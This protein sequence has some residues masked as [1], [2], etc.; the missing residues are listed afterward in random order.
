LIFRLVQYAAILLLG[1]TQSVVAASASLTAPIA[2]EDRIV[3]ALSQYSGASRFVEL[4]VLTSDDIAAIAMG[5]VV[6]RV[7]ARSGDVGA[8]EVDAAQTF[9]FQIIAAP[10]LHAWIALLGGPGTGTEGRFTRAMLER[11][12]EGAYVRYQHIDLPWPFQNRHWAILCSK[13]LALARQSDGLIWEHHWS[14]QP[15]G[16]A[17]VQSALSS[18]ILPASL[19]S[20]L[21]G[22]IYLPANRGAWILFDLGQGSTLVVAYM[23][24]GLGGGVPDAL[25]RTFAQRQLRS[26]FDTI[27]KKSTQAYA[28]YQADPVVHDGFG[29]PI[30]RGDR[31]VAGTA[32]KDVIT[33]GSTRGVVRTE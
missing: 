30:P 27:N 16:E 6:V 32:R 4:P 9:G 31:L 21:D 17:L 1:W 22:A 2:S 25:A 24:V 23:D 13:N 3:R 11:L 26:G 28:E 29:M 18:G 10:R 20:K 15:H 5:D 12:P 33:K 7:H 8:G 19:R 14:L